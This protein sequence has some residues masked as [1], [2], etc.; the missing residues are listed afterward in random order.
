MT[1]TEPGMVGRAKTVLVFGHDDEAVAVLS[2]VLARAIG[3]AGGERLVFTGPATFD[4]KARKHI[5]AVVLPVVD[6]ILEHMNIPSQRFELSVVNLAAASAEDIG[7]SISGFSADVPVFLALLSAT[8]RLPVPQ[9]VVATGHVASADGDL[10]PVKNIPAK[11]DAALRESA[12]GRFICP[13]TDED[14]S[15]QALSPSEREQIAQAVLR[16]RDHLHI[17]EAA[18]V[19][20][21]LR[22]VFASE[23]IALASLRAGFFG[24]ESHSELHANPIGRAAQFLLQNNDRRFWSAL[25][26]HLL[27]GRTGEARKLLLERATYQVSQCIYPSGF[28]C[29]LLQL[30]R[31]LPPA[32]RR[33]KITF[34]LLS[35]DRCIELGRFATETD[36]EDLR[37]LIDATS[38][39]GNRSRVF[40]S[41][42]E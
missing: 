26:T 10:R 34:P 16:A 42:L 39:K 36:H 30:V 24:R 3:D 21:L 15:L 33:L 11:L 27:A 20:T 25:Q 9:D 38:G 6:G 35:L 32:T 2:A 29:Q 17:I 37:H 1:T 23:T 7:V 19:A 13:P 14:G 4:E 18:D 31:S 40:C 8:L 22:A 12:I 5:E 28:G 41:I